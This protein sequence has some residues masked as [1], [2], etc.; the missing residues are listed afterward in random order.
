MKSL[1]DAAIKE[2]RIPKWPYEAF[3]D[4]IV[5]FIVPE[6]KA[7]R[8]TFVEGGKI[9]K[10]ENRKAAEESESPRGIIVSAGLQAR[11]IL[12][13]NGIGLGHMVWVARHSPWRHQVDKDQNGKDIEFFFLRAGDIV[14]S[15][16]TL[17]A[18]A[19]GDLTVETK[20]DGTH[21][22]K[23]KRESAR[24]RFDPPSYVA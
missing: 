24:P 9:V 7:A 2:H 21:C 10:V 4:R 16:D 15:E 5:V 20:P 18:I 6:D 1:L 14:G 23:Y 22:Y 8:D 17:G 3:A 11:D 13:S 12:R 19:K